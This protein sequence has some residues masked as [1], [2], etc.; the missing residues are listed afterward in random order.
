[1]QVKAGEGERT[2]CCAGPLQCLETLPFTWGCLGLESYP[3]KPH[4]VH[5]SAAYTDSSSG[6]PMLFSEQD[7]AVSWISGLQPC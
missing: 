6:H 5:L 2:H 3:A 1:M 4:L 7:L